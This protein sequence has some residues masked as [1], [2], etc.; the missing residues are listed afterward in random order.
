MK[1]ILPIL[2]KWSSLQQSVSKFMLKYFD[3]IGPWLLN[4][5]VYIYSLFLASW[6]IFAEC[7]I[8]LTV[9]KGSS[10]QKS[11]SKFTQKKFYEID[12]LSQSH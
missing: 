7:K 9:A 12:P 5:F 4:F 2:I 10:L 3:E 8:M 11:E 1:Q 6:T